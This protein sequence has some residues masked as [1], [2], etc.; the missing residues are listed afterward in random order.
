MYNPS[1]PAKYHVKTFGLC[2][3]ATGYCFN[4]LIYFGSETSYAAHIDP[5]SESAIKVFD[6]L[7]QPLAKGHHVFADRYYTTYNLV[8]H[9]KEKQFYYTGTVR[10]D[11]K[12]FPPEHKSLTK[13]L[14]RQE[15]RF[16]LSEDK[17]IM[18]VAWRDKKAKKNCLAVSTNSTT[19]VIQ[20]VNRRKEPIS[21]PEMI[22]YYNKFMGGCDL[23]DQMITYGGTFQRKTIKWWKKIFHWVIEIAV[24]NS[25]ILYKITR[26]PTTIKRPLS[27]QDYKD[28]L[29]R[30]LKE[31]ANLV[32][33]ANTPVPTPKRGRPSL[34]TNARFVNNVHL[35]KY[36]DEDRRCVVCS[37]P[38]ARKRTNFV[39]AG[40][41][42]EPHLHPKDCF[43]KY[44]T[45]GAMGDE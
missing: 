25:Y 23:M 29:I 15:S 11:R 45:P 30:Q 13:V 1:K 26:N 17:D 6:T 4:I 40:C 31:R 33:D 8:K 27:L 12:N 7:M 10:S 35:I 21:K 32:L 2:D 14:Q 41:P 24:V 19:N 42:G 36:V 16:F 38:P 9:L 18:T 39:C 28:I 44:H 3:S 34:E 20:Q 43:I 37:K 5:E 22:H